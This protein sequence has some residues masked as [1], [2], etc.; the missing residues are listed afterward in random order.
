[1]KKILGVSLVALMAVS[2]AR[3]D[4]VSKAYVD[5]DQSKSY[6]VITKTAKTGVQ[7]EELDA[8]MGALPADKTVAQAISEA[9]SGGIA[10]VVTH[11]GAVGNATTP[12]YIAADGT[13][14]AGTA[15][16]TA[17]YTDS[18]T[19]I[20]ENGTGLPTAGTVYTALAGKQDT[21]A[22][23][24]YDAYGAASTAKTTIDAYT[25]NTKAISTNPVLTG[26]DIAATGYAKASEASAIA[27]SD[28]V[29]AALGK[30]E[31]KIDAVDYSGKQNNL[32]GS[33]DAGKVVTATATAGTVSYTAIDT[34]TG[35]TAL[36][37][38]LITSGAVN[39]GLAT[40]QDTIPAGTY[41]ATVSTDSN[42]GNVVTAVSANTNGTVSVTTGNAIMET[43]STSTSGVSVLTRVSDGNGGYTYAWEPIQR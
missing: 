5:V 8:K 13:A 35:G 2:T 25:V 15:L 38:D 18:T 37:S 30:L 4:I 36:S 33:T 19:T 3:A 31:Y 41:V 27:A 21:I 7:I 29:N 43:S 39:A 9:V 14:T 22:A 6:N 26:A 20:A 11:S 34:T 17:A 10:N 32:G 1:M 28:T 42:N 24:T 16:G 23:N 40:K 12:V